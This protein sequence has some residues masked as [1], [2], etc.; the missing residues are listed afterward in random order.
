M[1]TMVSGVHPGHYLVR[2]LR[3]HRDDVVLELDGTGCAAIRP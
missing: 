2:A 1:T 3:Q